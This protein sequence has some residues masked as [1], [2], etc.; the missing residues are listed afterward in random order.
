MT[1]LPSTDK[2]QTVFISHAAPEDNQF[3]LWLSSKL[4]MAG[5][6]VWVDRNRLRGGD[7]FWD[8][9][10]KVLRDETIKQ[11][12]V[13][14]KHVRKPGVKKELA[15]GEIMKRKLSDDNFM[16]GVRAD[17]VENTDAPPEL[18]RSNILNAHPNWHDCLAGLLE[19]LENIPHEK[20]P[21]NVAINAIVSA[22]ED[23]RRFVNAIPE[24]ALTNWF[25]IDPPSNIRF[26]R[27][28]GLQDQMKVWQGECAFPHVDQGRLM[29]TFANLESVPHGDSKKPAATLAYDIPFL[30]FISGSNT[31]PY[32]DKQSGNKDIVNLLRQHFD[33]VAS[34]RGLLPVSFASGDVG[35]FFPDSLL[36]GNKVVCG[37]PDG[38]R[39]RRSVSGR[40][41][42][43][44]WHL[45]L[46]SKPRIWPTLVYRIHANIVLTEDGRTPMA[47]DKTHTR[48][49]RLTR[50]WWNDV[51]RDRMLAGMNYLANGEEYLKLDAGGQTFRVHTW[52]LLAEL[53]VSYEAFDAPLPSDEDDEGNIVPTAALGEHLDDL[54]DFPRDE[55]GDGEEK[56][57]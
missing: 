8:E 30:D 19:A 25:P 40:F 10:E 50:S 42:A 36:P 13:F 38:R 44:R 17:D 55:E 7:D 24:A 22:R 46:V 23:G 14:T 41:K 11:I 5:Y 52:P 53:P 54:D 33:E 57:P 9:I 16:I 4:T 1:T 3:A 29:T 45:C 34:E 37:T 15:L 56:Q 32:R 26:F 51:W 6:R 43:L 31:G 49:R 47:G 27:F 18:L 20:G 21:N 2:R 28:D 35:W 12:V 48:R 39:I